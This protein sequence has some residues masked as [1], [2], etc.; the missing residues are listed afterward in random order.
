MKPT[1]LYYPKCGTCRKAE[2]WLKNNVIDFE[3]RLIVENKPTEAEL[4]EW[5]KKAGLPINKLF[6]TS[7]LLY[8]EQ[9]IKDKVKILSNEELTRILASDGMMVKRPI[10]LLGEKVLFGFNEL[11]WSNALR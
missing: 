3:Y 10:L 5:Q 9:N 2:K 11:E 1:I 4:Q 6:N 7:G 8:R